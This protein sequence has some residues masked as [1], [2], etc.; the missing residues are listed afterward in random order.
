MSIDSVICDAGPHFFKFWDSEDVS[1][2]FL[3]ETT[4]NRTKTSFIVS[5]SFHIVTLS[6]YPDVSFS[7]VCDKLFIVHLVVRGAV[8]Q[9][10]TGRVYIFG[11]I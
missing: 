9:V 7:H 5:E 8:V 10:D 1:N 11:L 2:T 4:L 6:K 3:V